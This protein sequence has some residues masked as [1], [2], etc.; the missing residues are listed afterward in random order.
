MVTIVDAE[1]NLS[2]ARVG[3]EY[4]D[5][6]DDAL[7]RIRPEVEKMLEAEGSEYFNKDDGK[8]AVDVEVKRFMNL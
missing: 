1:I 8:K 2:C 5:L 6:T 7:E 3:I 4:E